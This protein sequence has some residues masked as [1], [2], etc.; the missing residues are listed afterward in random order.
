MFFNSRTISL[1]LALSV[2]FLSGTALFFWGQLT[3]SDFLIAITS[4]FSSTFFC[5]F[6]IVELLIFKEIRKI[7][8]IF[9]KFKNNNGNRILDEKISGSEGMLSQKLYTFANTKEKEIDKLR[10]LENFRREFLADISHELKTPVFTAQGFIHT[11]LDGAVDDLKVRDKFLTKAAKSLDD[12]NNIIQD[13]VNISQLE[14]GEIKLQMEYFDIYT[15]A[16]EVAELYEQKAVQYNVQIQI[17]PKEEKNYLVVGDRNRIGQVLKNLINNAI[18]YG[19]IDNQGLIE[20]KVKEK[21]NSVSLSVSDHGQGISEEHL[22]K[23]FN[24]FYRVDK[25]R[26]KELGGTGL[27]LSIVKHVLEA[28]NSQI[29]VAST[30]G[31]GTTFSFVLNKNF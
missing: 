2:S 22:E 1:I 6:I 5:V 21:K 19:R 8:A 23:I 30:V 10:K 28:H 26:S 18:L 25:S 20:I 12:L 3:L 27:G 24:R 15:L 14:T 29:Q 4:I 31:K 13:L 17:S 16:Q 11:L 9:N 7:L